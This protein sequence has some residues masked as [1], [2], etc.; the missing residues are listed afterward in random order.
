MYNQKKAQLRALL[1]NPVFNQSFPG[2]RGARIRQSLDIAFRDLDMLVQG[3]QARPGP[4][5][6]RLVAQAVR[7]IHEIVI[8]EPLNKFMSDFVNLYVEV[9]KNW[10]AQV[11]RVRDI[12]VMLDATA[13]LVAGY[14]TFLDTIDVM[15]RFIDRFE[16]MMQ[17]TP[18]S[19]DLSRHYLQVVLEKY[20]RGEPINRYEEAKQRVAQQKSSGKQISSAAGKPK[21]K[22]GS[23]AK[24]SA[25][26]GL[27]PPS[28]G[29]C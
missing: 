4:N 17:Y 25:D 10:N 24:E 13:R 23:K 3:G 27:Q 8:Y 2:Q 5:E 1:A 21:K 28:A 26:S 14:M 18:P 6:V 11:A 9:M 22:K 7:M 19:F 20:E 15:R 16:R 29:S 12:D